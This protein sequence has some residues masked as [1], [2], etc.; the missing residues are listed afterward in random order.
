[1]L[2]RDASW[3]VLLIFAS[4]CAWL[5]RR[6]R[7]RWK[8]GRE[9]SSPQIAKPV[10]ARRACRISTCGQIDTILKG[11]KRGPAVVP[12]K[13]AESL[14]YRAIA[15]TGELKMPPGKSPL[16]PAD[17]ETIRQWID[18]GAK[19]PAATAAAPRTAS[20]WAFRKP[21][22]PEMPA[23]KNSAWVRTPVDAFV[24]HKL[25]EKGLRPGAAARQG[26]AD[27]PRVLRSDWACR[28]R[29]K[30]SAAFVDDAVAGRVREADRAAARLAA[31]WRALGT[32][33]ARRGPLRRFHRLRKRP[34]LP[35]RLALPR[36]CDPLRSM[37]TSRTTSSCRSRSPPT[38][39]GRT[40]TNC[41]ASTSCRS[42]RPQNLERRIGTG[43]Y[44]VGPMDPSSALDGAQ[45]RYERLTD[46]ADTTGAAFLGLSMGCARCHD[47]KFDPISQKDYYRLQA[48]FAGSEPRDI[49]AVDAVKV[50]T[51]WKSINKQLEVD[52]LK[53]EVKRID[54]QVRKRTGKRKDLAGAYTP[55]ET[56]RA[57]QTAAQTRRKN[58]WRCRSRTPPR[59][60][61]R[62]ARSCRTCTSRSAATS[63]I[64]A[65]RSAPGFP[66]VL[67]DGE[68]L[69]C[70]AVAAARKALA[71][72]LTRPDHPLTARVMVNRIWQWHFGRGIVA[73][74]ND[75][76]RQGEP[77]THPELLDW[78]ATEFVAR[79]WSIKAMHRLMM[80][81]NTYRMSDAVRR[82][83]RR[84][85]R[86]EPLSLAH[87][88]DA[89]GCRRGARRR[90]GV[91]GHAESENG[92]TAGDS[93]AGA[94]MK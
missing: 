57:R 76:G 72:W 27:P 83:E 28:P 21:R 39:S 20:W 37:T 24:L 45:L 10:T 33:L 46:M 93:A 51:Y 53:A 82:E 36:L 25:E 88:P 41:R 68:D 8:C 66:A 79:G 19:W 3:R 52:H 31:I 71:L 43:M 2:I 62:I 50:V 65:R 47:H 48:I 56:G 70:D 34:L 23:V 11:G 54:D 14:L 81:S 6:N 64:P 22:R 32:P 87:E 49:P 4:A 13:S 30:T 90:A 78:L 69:D 35:E 73:T 91:R 94:R 26:G 60:C 58:T 38:R 84:D 44:T 89:A 61:W 15:Q 42:R 16:A 74:P 77:P 75:F 59:P 63:A 67:C 80:L 18:A 40:T 55:E 12:G 9:R 85:R 7:R 29:P 1:M 5:R 17:V 92:R 86:R